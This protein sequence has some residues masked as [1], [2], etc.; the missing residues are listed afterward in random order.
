MAFINSVAAVIH[1]TTS[2]WDGEC[3]KNLGSSFLLVWRIGQADEEIILKRYIHSLLLDI[4]ITARILTDTL[5]QVS[6]AMHFASDSG[7]SPRNGYF[8]MQKNKHIAERAQYQ[9]L[10]R[11]YISQFI[12][13]AAEQ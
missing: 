3:N 10:V 8:S 4:L 6:R 11:V 7:Y 9:R 13:A 2:A 12:D 5:L 1:A